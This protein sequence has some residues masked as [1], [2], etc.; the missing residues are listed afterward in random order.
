[1]NSPHL[2][3]SLIEAIQN[4]LKHVPRQQL[5]AA[6]K[7]LSLKY[8]SQDDRQG[9]P[10]IATP[11]QR[12]AYLA[13]RL[14][15]TFAAV[16]TVLQA[17]KNIVPDMSPKSLN[18]IGAGPGTA[19]LAFLEAFPMMQQA[20]LFEMDA[21]MIAIGKRLIPNLNAEWFNVNLS[22][23]IEF[24]LSDMSI[25]SYALGE[26]SFEDADRLVESAWKSSAQYLAIIEPGTPRGFSYINRARD[27][28]LAQGA[29][30]VAPCPHQNKCPMVAPDWC[31]FSCRL[32]R[33]EMHLLVK[34][35]DR[36]FEDE[37]FSY[38]VAA[39]HP[40]Q[41]PDAR[42]LRHPEHHSGHTSVV[43]CTPE[44]L[45]KETISRKHGVRYKQVKK[46]SWGDP[47]QNG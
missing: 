4:E 3:N 8:R 1:M 23:T 5:A 33:T 28:L 15:A 30:I 11:A 46:A 22:Q 47:L 14:P 29:F 12:L 43:L 45:K 39:R 19:T 18:D 16:A 42:I 2:P 27:L 10:L 13:V 34:E 44:G 17:T 38:I 32:N 40:A 25:I 6:A 35:V 9:P 37:K 20:H 21:E 7:D 36:G 24:P 41:L 26:L 31:H